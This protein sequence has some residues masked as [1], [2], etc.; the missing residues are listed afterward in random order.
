MEAVSEVT[1]RDLWGRALGDL[2]TAIAI[3]LTRHLLDST[4]QLALALNGKDG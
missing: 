3:F 2:L 1:A 4:P